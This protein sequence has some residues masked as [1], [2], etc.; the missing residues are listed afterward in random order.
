[1][2]V[3]TLS[4]LAI[5][6]RLTDSK[7]TVSSKKGSKLRTPPDTKI[8]PAHTSASVSEGSSS[9]T[10]DGDNTEKRSGVGAQVTKPAL[11]LTRSRGLQKGPAVLTTDS[12]RAASSNR[13]R[14]R[15]NSSRT[16]STQ[17]A[18][19]WCIV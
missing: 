19:E 3:Y 6:C 18:G 14:S 13:C 11:G 12:G 9:A 4:K 15:C 17:S 8:V 7:V 10:D 1:M 2:H 16:A 5:L